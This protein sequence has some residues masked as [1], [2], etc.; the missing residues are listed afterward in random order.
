MHD[1]Q[2]EHELFLLKEKSVI[3][4]QPSFGHVSTSFSGVLHV[5]ND[6]P[7]IFHFR[8]N[9]GDTATIFCVEDVNKLEKGIPF[10]VI[11]LKGPHE[12]REDYDVAHD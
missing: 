2:L 4:V 8:T 1:E 12:Y 9:S 10:P 6:V 5:V 7:V 11:R 3:L